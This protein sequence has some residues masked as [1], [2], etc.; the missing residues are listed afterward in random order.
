MAEP[1]ITQSLQPADDELIDRI[2]NSPADQPM[3]QMIVREASLFTL[4]VKELRAVCDRN[5]NHPKARAFRDGTARHRPADE[6]SVERIDL[7]ALI[8]DKQIVT[9]ITNETMD[10][11]DGGEPQ[12]GVPVE[13]KSLG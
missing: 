7:E 8:L 4:S 9:T 1:E 10:F 12:P 11:N 3:R 5:P 2:L 6:V 13:R